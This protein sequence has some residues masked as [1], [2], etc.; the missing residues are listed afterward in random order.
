MMVESWSF[1]SW[2][3]TAHSGNSIN[4]Y[5][6]KQQHREKNVKNFIIVGMLWGT[7]KNY[8]KKCQIMI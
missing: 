8:S 7:G 2:N 6:I 3:E 5:W 1:S 4:V